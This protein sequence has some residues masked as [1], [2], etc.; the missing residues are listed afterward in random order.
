[1]LKRQKKI[2][3]RYELYVESKCVTQEH[4]FFNNVKHLAAMLM[5]GDTQIAE[6]HIFIGIL[7]DFSFLFWSTLDRFVGEKINVSCRKVT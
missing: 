5:L 2:N 1:M 4:F 6:Q 7:E 3:H